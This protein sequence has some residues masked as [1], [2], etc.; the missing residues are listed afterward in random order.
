M[1]PIGIAV[2]TGVS[3]VFA[4]AAWS[5]PQRAPDEDEDRAPPSPGRPE[6]LSS[7]RTWFYRHQFGIYLPLVLIVLDRLPGAPGKLAFGGLALVLLAPL[8]WNSRRLMQV[9][10][11][12]QSL[13]VS[14]LSEEL[15]VPLTWVD[16]VT[17]SALP[18]ISLHPVT[19]HL[20]HATPFGTRI[21]FVPWSWRGPSPF[22]SP[23]VVG[24]IT[25][26]A[27]RAQQQPQ[28]KVLPN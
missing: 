27:R 4:W 18:F 9:R 6:L 17:D 23:P 24:R 25:E 3:A 13:Y 21:R 11:D 14:D 1:T 26:A 19:I 12:E 2:L 7:S 5:P 10:M 15:V 22:L 20:K 8:F 16:H 28:A